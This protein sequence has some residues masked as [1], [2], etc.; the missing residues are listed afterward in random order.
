MI[1]YAS[2]VD[3]HAPLDVVWRIMSNVEQWHT[4]TPTIRSVKLLVPGPLAPGAKARIL[5]PKL[6]PAIWQVT[7]L[8]AG[9]D[10]TWVNRTP[11]LRVIGSHSIQPTLDGCRATVAIRFAGLLAP[12]VGRLVRRLNEDY[13]A[14]EAKGLKEYAEALVATP[15]R[16]RA[17]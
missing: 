6:P 12:I 10:F 2:S 15:Q 1:E 9:R 5:Q 11:G 16:R 8:H 17:I 7:E 13:L 4:W 3:I 14:L